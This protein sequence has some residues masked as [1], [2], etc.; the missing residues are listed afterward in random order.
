MTITSIGSSF[1]HIRPETVGRSAGARAAE[2]A[3]EARESRDTKPDGDES[4]AAPQAKGSSK[5]SVADEL[6]AVLRQARERD[7]AAPRASA[8]E[9]T[10][11]YTGR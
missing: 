1:S 9:A 7:Q 3:T 10:R 6:Q 4:A 5:P 2:E 11:A 8:R